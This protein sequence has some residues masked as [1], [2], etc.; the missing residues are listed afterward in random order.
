MID[1][2][3]ALLAVA[4]WVALRFVVEFLNL[5]ERV[6]RWASS[7]RAATADVSREVAL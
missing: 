7:A 2:G 5:E 6:G 3:T 4:A 1:P